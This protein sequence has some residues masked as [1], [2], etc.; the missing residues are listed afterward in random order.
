M[1]ATI[2]RE[3]PAYAGQFMVYEL[4]KRWL[5]TLHHTDTYTGTVR[6]RPLSVVSLL[7]HMRI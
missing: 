1:S 3:M 5:I 7:L 4:V 2:Y 6:R